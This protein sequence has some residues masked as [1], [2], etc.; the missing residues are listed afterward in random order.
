MKDTPHNN[1]IFTFHL[2]K[3]PFLS[4]IRNIFFPL[5]KKNIK[6]LIHSESFCI[7]NLGETIASPS[8]YN[9]NS[10]AFFM[11]W[12]SESDLKKFLSGSIGILHVSFFPKILYLFFATSR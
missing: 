9:W 8:R 5:H 3:M 12:S 2:V 1:E 10:I 6:G 7:M 11:W 4:L